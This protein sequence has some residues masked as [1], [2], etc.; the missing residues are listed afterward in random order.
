LFVGTPFPEFY[1][2]FSPDGRWLAYQSDESGTVE[3]YVRPFRG[4][5]GRWQISKGGGVVPVWSRDGRELLFETLDQ[6]V[7]AVGYSAM[8]D[9]FLAGKPRVWSETHLFKVS[10]MSVYDLAP[11]GKRLA[12]ILASDEPGGNATHLTFLLNFFDELRRRVPPGGK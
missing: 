12:A 10:G 11:D 9:S 7:M 1:P 2:A 4:P 3:V 5:G 8:G 6:R